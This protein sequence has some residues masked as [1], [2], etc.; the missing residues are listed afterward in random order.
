MKKDDDLLKLQD[1]TTKYK[2]TIDTLMAIQD[3]DRLSLFTVLS[4]AVSYLNGYKISDVD[5][6][7]QKLT[8]NNI[9]QRYGI[10]SMKIL[11]EK[12]EE[13]AVNLRTDG[14][15]RKPPLGGIQ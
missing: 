1:P 8:V 12:T 11:N 2:N 6:D 7:K 5:N 15:I 13:C 4:I 9:L 3:E 10:H 14:L